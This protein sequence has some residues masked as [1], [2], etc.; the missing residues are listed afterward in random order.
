MTKHDNVT[1]TYLIFVRAATTVTNV[2]RQL[3]KVHQSALNVKV[4][5]HG[6]K[7]TNDE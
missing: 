5:S 4:A 3:K 6:L 7:I 1:L 2:S